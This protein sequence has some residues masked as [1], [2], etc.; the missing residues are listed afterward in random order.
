MQQL[1]TEGQEAGAGGEVVDIENAG[2]NIILRTA[3]VNREGQGVDVLLN[4]QGVSLG[5]S[6]GEKADGGEGQSRL[7]EDVAVS[8]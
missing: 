7:L 8:H 2:N 4:H 1:E 5:G 3:D 6:A